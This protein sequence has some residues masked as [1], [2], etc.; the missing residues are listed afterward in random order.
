MSDQ[1]SVFHGLVKEQME[2]L[3]ENSR[4]EVRFG[5]DRVTEITDL[6]EVIIARAEDGTVEHHN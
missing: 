1:S 3:G 2:R 4:P 5:E 6:V